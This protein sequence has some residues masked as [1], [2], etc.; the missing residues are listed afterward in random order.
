M[1]SK[2]SLQLLRQQPQTVS[3]PSIQLQ[4]P[5]QMTS[6]PAWRRLC[7][8]GTHTQCLCLSNCTQITRGRCT[9]VLQHPCTP[10][11][12]VTTPYLA[13]EVLGV[14]AACLQERLDCAQADV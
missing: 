8:K 5:I 3:W 9:G 4:H 14:A 13:S 7:V 12:S 1:S 6:Q 2:N 10:Y 11:T